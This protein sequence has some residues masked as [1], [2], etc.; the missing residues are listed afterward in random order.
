MA[1][2]LLFLALACYCSGVLGCSL[3]SSTIHGQVFIVTRGGESVKLGLVTVD[4]LPVAQFKRHVAA[5]KAEAAKELVSRAAEVKSWN[6]AVET[7][8][9]MLTTAER[10][11]RRSMDRGDYFGSAYDKRRQAVRLESDA[12]RGLNEARK[13]LAMLSQGAFYFEGMPSGKVS[14]QTDADGNF[15]L[16][17][18]PLGEYVLV[19]R[20]GRAIM[21]R[22]E[23]YFWA[24]QVMPEAR[25]GKP[26]FL[27]NTTMTTANSPLSLLQTTE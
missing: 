24:V 23:N 13:K 25:R 19:A 4:L 15:A 17:V 5:R 27:S 1:R 21:D 26:V 16:A 8:Q 9:Q 14:A 10:E 20:A 18:P 6:D 11:Y 2:C 7:S 3:G 22:A 12:Q